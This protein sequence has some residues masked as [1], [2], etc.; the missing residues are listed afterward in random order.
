M[1]MKKNP[2]ATKW[3]PPQIMDHVR[4]LVGQAGLTYDELAVRMGYGSARRSNAWQAMQSVDPRVSTICRFARALSV[5][6]S[7]LLP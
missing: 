1:A 2:N 6:V 4:E 3:A 7:D 5:P